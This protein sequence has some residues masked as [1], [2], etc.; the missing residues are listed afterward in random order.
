MM[1]GGGRF[2]PLFIKLLRATVREPQLL[3]KAYEIL[4]ATVRKANA[5]IIMR[6]ALGA[7]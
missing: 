2:G 3:T 5:N 6:A 1:E 4:R 7:D